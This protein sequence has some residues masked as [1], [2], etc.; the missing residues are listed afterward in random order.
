MW[1]RMVLTSLTSKGWTLL[2]IVVA[3]L[4]A[5]PSLLI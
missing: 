5:M 3:V 2:P 1:M 4:P